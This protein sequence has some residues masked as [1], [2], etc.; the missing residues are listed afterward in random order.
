MRTALSLH[1]H[2]RGFEHACKHGIKLAQRMRSDRPRHVEREG[3]R[4]EAA[5]IDVSA[6]DRLAEQALEQRSCFLLLW[7]AIEGVDRLFHVKT[8][9]CDCAR[10][11]RAEGIEALSAHA[12]TDYRTT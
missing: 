3:S 4:C 5:E 12:P 6:C 9:T 1:H 8:S 10:L 7:R 2:S 11:V